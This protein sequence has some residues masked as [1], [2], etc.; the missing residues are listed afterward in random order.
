MSEGMRAY[1][2][3][4][5]ITIPK[6]QEEMMNIICDA[7]EECRNMAHCKDCP[8][9]PVTNMRMMACT[10]LKYTRLLLENGYKR[11]SE[12]EKVVRCKDCKY[13]EKPMICHFREVKEMVAPMDFCCW[14][15]KGENK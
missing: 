12:M 8:D 11:Q 2:E 3:L 10:A 1:E 15:K 4:K 14:G 6:E 5:D 7:W 13:F 9:R